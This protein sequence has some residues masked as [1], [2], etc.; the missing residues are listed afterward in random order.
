MSFAEAILDMAEAGR[1]GLHHL[2]DEGEVSR[3]DWARRV[4]RLAGVE[5]EVLETTTPS[6][7][8]P[9]Q[10]PLNCRLDCSEGLVALGRAMPHWDANLQLYMELAGLS[11]AAGRRV[12]R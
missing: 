11:Q 6:R 8:D 2:T 10:R 12:G 3:A 4:L 1:I 9:A 5:R 7:G